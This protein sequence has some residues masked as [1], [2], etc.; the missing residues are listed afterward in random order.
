VSTGIF[1]Y[2]YIFCHLSLKC[3]FSLTV[4]HTPCTIQDLNQESS[5]KTLILSGHIRNS[6]HLMTSLG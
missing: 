3:L 1:L 2:F 4:L 6:F 5:L